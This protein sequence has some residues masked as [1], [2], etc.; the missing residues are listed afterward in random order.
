MVRLKNEYKKIIAEFETDRIKSVKQEIMDLCLSNVKNRYKNDKTKA[1]V[2]IVLPIYNAEPYLRECLDSCIHQT[3]EDIEIICVNDGSTD[4]S[5]KIIK[6]YADKDIRI[7]YIDKPNAGYGQTMNC[8]M[9]L[10]S[11]EYIGIVEPDDF[12]KLDMYETLYKKAKSEN[13]DIVKSDYCTFDKKSSQYVN[14]VSKDLYNIN[15]LHFFC[16]FS[17]FYLY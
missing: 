13:F 10:A 15:I 8:G 4:N 11:G 12:I 3:L 16:Y 7:R 1:K 6:E 9:A 5:L 2:S 14:I 17:L